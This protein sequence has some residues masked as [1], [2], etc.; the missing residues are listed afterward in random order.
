MHV[1]VARA[2]A[3]RLTRGFSL[4]EVVIASALLL[5]TVTAVT[6]SVTSLSKASSH[7]TRAMDVDRVL[8]REVARLHALSYCAASYPSASRAVALAAED[9]GDVVGE[10]FP[11]A[12]AEASTESARYVVV[13]GEDAPAGSFV[14]RVE[15]DGITVERVARFIA[16]DGAS[17]LSPD[18]L[19]GWAVWASTVPPAPTL[20]ISLNALGGG[21]RRSCVVVCSAFSPSLAGVSESQSGG[22][23]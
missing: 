23:G 16:S 21:Y 18:V 12:V 11:H 9:H 22:G 1:T 6:A 15:S 8:R 13:G 7:L 5:M 19:D 3:G 10:V 20:R 2:S 14:T 17:P 4:L